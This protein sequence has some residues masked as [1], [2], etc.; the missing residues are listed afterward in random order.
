MEM[1]W[2]AYCI[3]EQSSVQQGRVRRPFQIEQL[4]GINSSPVLGFPT[5]EFVVLVSDYDRNFSLTQQAV[6][7]HARVVSECFRQATVLPFRFATVFETDD[8]LRHAVRSNRKT[9]HE[10][11]ER[12]RGKA[13]MHIKVTMR[14]DGTVPEAFFHALPAGVGGQYLERL[15]VIATRDR[16]RQTKA[17][18]V[19]VQVNKL[20]APLEHETSCKHVD[21][22]LVIDIAH[23]IDATSLQKYHNRYNSATRQLK[24]CE[25]SISGPWPPYHFMR[26]KLRTVN[27]TN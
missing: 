1:T 23:L 5:G 19:S 10:S 24:N 26:G 2:Y 27:G 18:A 14:E 17:R 15:H 3:T 12:L 6:V 16:E 11:L 9:F 7:D 22:G 13:E 21:A 4:S 25:I 20:L 8:A